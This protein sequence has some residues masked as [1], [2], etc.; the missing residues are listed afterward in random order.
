MTENRHSPEGETTETTD[1]TSSKLCSPDP[2]TH[3]APIKTKAQKWA[4]RVAC[5]VPAQAT[6][7]SPVPAACS[8]TISTNNASEA[9]NLKGHHLLD[10]VK[11]K[12]HLSLEQSQENR[13]LEENGP[14]ATSKVARWAARAGGLQV[15]S[16]VVPAAVTA[17]LATTVRLEPVKSKLNCMLLQQLQ[18]NRQQEKNSPAATSKVARWAARAGGQQLVSTVVP[19][20]V[21][22][23]LATTVQLEATP[24][25]PR[26]VPG[27]VGL[28]SFPDME[29]PT[30][31]SAME[32]WM[33][34]AAANRLH[35]PWHDKFC[36]YEDEVFKLHSMR[37]TVEEIIAQRRHLNPPDIQRSFSSIRTSVEIPCITGLGWA[38][39]CLDSRAAWCPAAND[40][41][42]WM[43][44]DLLE[45]MQIYGIV[46]QGQAA[47][48][49]SGTRGICVS[50]C[51]PPHQCKGGGEI[52]F[53]TE[54][55]VMYRILKTDD[56]KMISGPLKI[57][58]GGD[59]RQETVFSSS[60]R[61]RYVRIQVTA[62]EKN[63]AL[64]A[65]II[66]MER[67]ELHDRSPF[68]CR[69]DR[70]AV[71][72]TDVSASTSKKAIDR[73]LDVVE[74]GGAVDRDGSCKNSCKSA[75][76]RGPAPSLALTAQA[77]PKQTKAQKW[78][79]RAAAAAA[80]SAAI[81][82]VPAQEIAPSQV[83]AASMT[84][85]QKWAAR[86]A[87][88][89]LVPVASLA[90]APGAGLS[91]AFSRTPAVA[92]SPQEAGEGTPF[93]AQITTPELTFSG[94]VFGGVPCL[95][96]S[97]RFANGAE[98]HGMLEKGI[99][100]G[101][102]DSGALEIFH[103]YALSW[104][105]GLSSISLLIVMLISDV[106]GMATRHILFA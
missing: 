9:H 22:A 87:G 82:P 47:T 55:Q 30:S 78:A 104:H 61:A 84:K 26:L 73:S 1:P 51:P 39:S 6:A 48:N 8:Q 68:S 40:E 10:P 14:A 28:F 92:A 41:S 34:R 17:P 80:A 43:E 18:E 98:Y 54:V 100:H 77:S 15:A 2:T 106:A 72:A 56:F 24:L 102:G 21:T 27:L 33:Q 20:A 63:I 70:A 12:L 75:A 50:L 96:G 29:V 79:S 49:C 90:E 46:T 76:A 42:Q 69:S 45:E 85:A 5:A 59:K 101:Q 89:P 38:R 64:R 93:Y 105:Q 53:T 86:A 37:L 58:G 65:G 32:V 94:Y 91:A 11:S 35:L 23:P 99:P 4:D 52:N 31:G 97:L 74:P 66:I 7:R 19:A 3:A 16:T 103:Q 67:K 95:K 62:W 13:Q 57:G 36:D 81:V 71:P 88:S 25:G 83:P 60:V 44:I